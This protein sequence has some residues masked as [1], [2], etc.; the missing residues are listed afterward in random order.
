MFNVSDSTSYFNVKS[1]KHQHI[2]LISLNRPDDKNR[3]N[4]AT[5]EDLKK[6]I[7]DFEN[8]SSSTVAVL[9]G[10]GGSFCAGWEPEELIKAPQIF[11]V[12]HFCFIN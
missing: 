10:E 2:T 9:Y 4:T 12:I 3:L 11:N 6:A 1:F 5:L 7:S 8:D